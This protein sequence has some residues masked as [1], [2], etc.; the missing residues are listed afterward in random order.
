MFAGVPALEVYSSFQ[1]PLGIFLVGLAA[2]SLIASIWGGW[3]ALAAAAAVVLLPDAYQ[4]GFA[5]RYL[6][7][8][9]LTQVNLTVLYGIAC[10]AMAW[11][12]VLEGSRRGKPWTIL[13]GYVFLG[14]CLFYK[15]QI[16]VANAFLI[17]IYPWLFF[18]GLRL[19][20][21]ALIVALL[22]ALF[23]T[24]IAFSQTLT[25]VPLISL[26]GSGLNGYVQIL[27]SCFDPGYLKNFFTQVFML[28]QH[29]RPMVWLYAAAMILLSSFGWWLVATPL[30]LAAGRAK[31]KAEIFYWPVLIVVN[32]M[33]MSM[34]LA[35]DTHGVGTPDELLNR[36]LV[37]AYF[38][39]VAWTVGGGYFFA[40]GNRLP[41][42]RLARA[43]LI[44]LLCLG[45]SSPLV[46]GKRL[47]TF[48]AWKGF[49]DYKEF[50]AVPLCLLKASQYIK[51]NSRQGDIM[52]DSAND[53]HYLVAALTERQIFAGE[54]LFAQPKGAL[55]ERLYGLEYFKGM[56]DPNA[57][58]TYA[59]VN[60]IAWYLLQPGS[61]VAWPD[62]FLQQA[63]YQC[64]GY[65]VY[66][67]DRNF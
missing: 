67:F 24:V 51:D 17:L 1:L 4:Q 55:L 38:A 9:F 5:N 18:N 7:Y 23:V 43:A 16:F 64:G 22:T 2:F 47:Q 30:V 28:E 3:P 49:T 62:A 20:W 27:L 41:R 26:D 11:I 53:R 29:A 14:L 48:P 45:L 42:S 21:R 65:R 63:A 15:A 6:S 56:R 13:A 34:G 57:I 66:R 59:A 32:Y 46:L 37:W 58:L 33:V 54:N 25:R 44:G 60:N 52:Q 19:R 12:F 31:T 10:A 35:L 40:L 50:N 39:V 61:P 36:P 8:N